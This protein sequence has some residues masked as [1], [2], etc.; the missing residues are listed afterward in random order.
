MKNM[1]ERFDAWDIVMILLTLTFCV[2]A[3]VEALK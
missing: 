2:T 3:I 1:F